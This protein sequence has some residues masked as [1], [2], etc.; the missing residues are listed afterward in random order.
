ML[1]VQDGSLVPWTAVWA[2]PLGS[3]VCRI[4]DTYNFAC[5]SAVSAIIIYAVF[6]KGYTGL[7]IIGAVL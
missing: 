5:I 3:F 4:A 7:L 1:F 2:S 6:R